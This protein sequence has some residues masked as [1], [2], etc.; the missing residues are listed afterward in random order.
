MPSAEVNSVMIRPHPPRLRMKRRKTVSVTPA[1]GARTVAG[2]MVTVPI[3]RRL[4]TGSTGAASREAAE[5]LPE[6]SQNLRI[7]Q[8]PFT[9]REPFT[10]ED[11]ED[12][13]ETDW[14][15]FMRRCKRKPP[16]GRGLDFFL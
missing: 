11:T 2:A 14:F 12:A 15:Y 8:E 13:E 10:T 3:W 6:L 1:M 5:P 4:G 9:T 16:P 7:G